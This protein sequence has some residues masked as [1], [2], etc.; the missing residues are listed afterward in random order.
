MPL[1]FRV[2]LNQEDVKKERDDTRRY[3][4]IYHGFY[5]RT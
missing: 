2:D 5:L 3:R 1:Q 4:A